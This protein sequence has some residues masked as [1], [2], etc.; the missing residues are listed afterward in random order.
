VD[1]AIAFERPAVAT[2]PRRR[3]RSRKATFLIWLRRIHLYVGLWGA[4]LGL[5]FGATGI[6]LNH[7]AV[8]KIPVE[9]TVL[10]SVQ[11][12]LPAG[13]AF[14]SPDAMARWLEA[15][16]RF[17][18]LQTRVKAEPAAT[19]RWADRDVLQPTRWTFQLHAPRRGV[20]AEFY[21]GNRF[22]KA[23]IQDATPIGTL[24]RLHMSVGVNA[25]WVLLADT[26]AGGLIVLSLTG[27]LL[28][29]R[30]HKVRLT[31]VVVALA[32]VTAA[33]GFLWSASV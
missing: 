2:P 3:S 22:V 15:E 23:D 29:T 19:V 6:L 5:L 20:A 21:V 4:V 14:D 1:E 28:W 27:L 31:G 30:L 10:R 25:F 9:K 12:A 18:A 16:L 17:D 24:T 33:V 8:L 13:R 7:R 11:I 26:I 32:A